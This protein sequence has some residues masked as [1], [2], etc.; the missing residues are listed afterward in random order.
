[1]RRPRDPRYAQPE[2]PSH[3]QGRPFGDPQATRRHHESSKIQRPAN[4]ESTL[5]EEESRTLSGIRDHQVAPDEG[6]H[7]G[8]GGAAL[9]DED[10]GARR[11]GGF[12]PRREFGKGRERR[13]DGG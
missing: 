11:P 6:E 9:G 13:F 7:G 12:G 2:R 1:P 10:L 8:G 3:P 5:H 4:V